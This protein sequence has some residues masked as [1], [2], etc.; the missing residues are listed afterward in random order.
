MAEPPGNPSD[1]GGVVYPGDEAPKERLAQ[2]MAN[3][4]EKAG[5]PPELPVMAALTE[6]GL[7]NVTTGDADS[8]GYGDWIAEVER[9]APQ[10]RSRYQ[11]RLE[12][13]RE[14]IGSPAVSDQP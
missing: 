11:T 5:L 8:A 10:Y 3:A 1:E 14:L 12:E 9:P 13:A 4:A 6:T 7:R 2:W